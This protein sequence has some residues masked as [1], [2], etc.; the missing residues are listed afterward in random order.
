MP[1]LID[2]PTRVEA[3]GTKPKII[4]EF[5]GRLS[6]KTESVS[7]AH[8]RSPAGWL[9]P[10]QIPEFDEYTIVCRARCTVTLSRRKPGGAAGPGRDRA[11]R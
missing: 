10:G 11:S 4:E 1:T 3:A 2:K 6:S 9:E 5:I 7:V 8:M